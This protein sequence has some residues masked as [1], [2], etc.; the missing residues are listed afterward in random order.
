[1]LSGPRA[2]YSRIATS[3][4]IAVKSGAMIHQGGIVVAEG[5]FATSGRAALALTAIGMATETIDNTTGADGDQR[6]HV[7][8]G[9]FLYAN[10][11]ADPVGVASLNQPVFIEDDETVSATDDG[12]ARSPAGVCF[13]V[14]DTGVWVRFT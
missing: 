7:E 6:V 2:T 3:L 12:G 13:D 11:A 1:M 10:S 14:D 5:G 4:S 9:C 8:K